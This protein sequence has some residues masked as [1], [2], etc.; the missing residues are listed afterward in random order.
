[1]YESRR[2]SLREKTVNFPSIWHRKPNFTMVC[3]SFQNQEIQIM[4]LKSAKRVI[5][6]RH[7]F[8]PSYYQKAEINPKAEREVKS[9]H[10][11]IGNN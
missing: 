6:S 3:V 9:V 2:Q 7:Y 11:T 8:T 4:Q 1:M 5:T 10:E